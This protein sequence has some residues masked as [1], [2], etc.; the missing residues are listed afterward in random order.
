M[1]SIGDA[2]KDSKRYLRNILIDREE[3]ERMSYLIMDRGGG[4][5]VERANMHASERPNFTYRRPIVHSWNLQMGNSDESN[6]MV[7]L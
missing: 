6:P 5:W 3:V 7:S 4:G 1:V 2:W